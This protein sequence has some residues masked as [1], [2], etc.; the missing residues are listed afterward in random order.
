MASAWNWSQVRSSSSWL[1]VRAAATAVLNAVHTL[2]SSS[3]SKRQQRLA[4]PGVA[5]D[6][7]AHVALPAQ[8]FV[9]GQPAVTAER[10]GQVAD[11][12]VELLRGHRRR[13]VDQRLRVLRQ[14]RRLASSSR[15][16]AALTM[17]STCPAPIVPSAN[18]SATAGIR[19]H[20]VPRAAAASASRLARR[21][22][23]AST[24]AGASPYPS[25]ANRAARPA[26]R[27]S[28]ESS[29]PRD[30]TIDAPTHRARH[31]PSRPGRRR[32]TRRTRPTP[33]RHRADHPRCTASNSCTQS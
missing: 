28:T 33:S 15:W 4:H 10:A 16:R 31:G 23:P 32:A 24:V 26:I 29:Q 18:A 2:A 3:G 27:A 30:A 7:A 14:R 5:V 22:P 12:A 6:P 11:L 20:T 9:T 13:G 1:A 25:A 8:P 19:A 17:A 21:P